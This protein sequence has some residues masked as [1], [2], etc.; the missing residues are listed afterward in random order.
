MKITT[1]QLRQIIR[2][3]IRKVNEGRFLRPSSPLIEKDPD[4]GWSKEDQLI[5]DLVSAY[6]WAYGK[7]WEKA[8]KLSP[9]DPDHK[10]LL[11]KMEELSVEIDKLVK[12]QHQKEG[13]FLRFASPL[14]EKDPKPNES[15][16]PEDTKKVFKKYEDSVK[17]L[18][19][20]LQPVKKEDPE[21]YKKSVELI[22][23]NTEDMNVIMPK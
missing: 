7:V 21:L 3:E 1:G 5:D 2:E 11:K 6:K 18:L 12:K 23:K 9:Q 16:K 13:R 22:K 4:S 20:K 10:K 19:Q 8:K 14:I 15:I 17:K